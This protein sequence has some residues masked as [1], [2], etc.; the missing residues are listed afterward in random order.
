[1]SMRISHIPFYDRLP[2]SS[3]RLLTAAAVYAVPVMLLMLWKLQAGIIMAVAPLLFLTVAH[4]PTAIMILI[5]AS[6]VYIPLGVDI[7]LLPADLA[8][9]VLI[10]AYVVDLLCRG[11]SPVRNRIARPYLAYLLVIVISLSLEGFTDLS[12]RFFSRQVV[13]FG[14]FAAVAHFGYKIRVRHFL[15]LMIIAAVVNSS[16]SLSQFLMAG[17]Q[18]R[19]F[20]AAGLGFGDHAMLAFLISVVYYF[21]SRDLRARFLYGMAAIITMGG[22]VATQTRASIITAMWGLAIVIFLALWAGARLSRK[23]PRRNLFIAGALVLLIVPLL[24]LYTPIFEGIFYRFGRMGLEAT[25]TILLRVSLWKAALSAFWANP[26]FGIGTGNFAAIHLW[27]PEVRFDPIFYLVAGLSTHAL[28]MTAL[29]ETGLAGFSTLAYFLVR[30]V[31]TAFRN[32]S[33]AE[34]NYDIA[35]THCLLAVA[36]AVLGSSIYA[37]SWFWG[38]NSYHMAIFFGLIASYRHHPDPPKVGGEE[39]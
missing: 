23:S 16:F 9:F 3:L 13:L 21:W 2:V 15:Q 28:A 4:G 29:A 14:T 1:M 19:T 35:D 26:L 7:F 31:K 30:A 22:M 34:S 36:I 38:N 32:F 11:A 6:F 10:A 24:A 27:I 12:V 33:E 39:A 25:G 18:I 17:G 8:A 5:A 20:G 37:G